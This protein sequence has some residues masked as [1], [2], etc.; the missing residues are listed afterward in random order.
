M[1]NKHNRFVKRAQLEQ[2]YGNYRCE[3]CGVLLPTSCLSVINIHKKLCASAP[4]NLINAILRP[5]N[6]HEGD[7]FI[8]SSLK[9]YRGQQLKEAMQVME[10]WPAVM[11]VKCAGG[12]MDKPYDHFEKV[13]DLSGFAVVHRSEYF[14]D[15]RQGKETSHV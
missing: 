1:A 11:T 2:S 12:C 9:G 5:G 7:F 4:S 6:V 15:H 14:E 10:C 3:Y 13:E 8:L